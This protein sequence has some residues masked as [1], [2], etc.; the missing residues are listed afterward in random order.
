MNNDLMFDHEH[1]SDYQEYILLRIKLDLNHEI[2]F[3][4]INLL[5]EASVETEQKS[6]AR[7]FCFYLNKKIISD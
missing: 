6:T 4:L 5:D 2:N 7:D 3:K 1:R